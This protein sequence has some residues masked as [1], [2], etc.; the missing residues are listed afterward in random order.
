MMHVR[1]GALT[2]T[3]VTSVWDVHDIETA[4]GITDNW[5]TLQSQVMDLT[6]MHVEENK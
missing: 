6:G 4:G 3:T 1:H 5:K 2:L